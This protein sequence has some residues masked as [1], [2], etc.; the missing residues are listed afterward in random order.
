M[1][2]LQ[3][4]V[5]K[6]S[7]FGETILRRGWTVLMA[8]LEERWAVWLSCVLV[9]QVHEEFWGGDF[10]IAKCGS[11]VENNCENRWQMYTNLVIWEK[12]VQFERCADSPPDARRFLTR[13]HRVLFR[14]F[15]RQLLIPKKIIHSTVKHT[16][17][18]FQLQADKNYPGRC[19]L[20]ASLRHI[21]FSSAI[22]WLRTS[23]ISFSFT[24]NSASFSFFC[25][26]FISESAE[27]GHRISW[28]CR[29]YSKRQ[30]STYIMF[31]LDID[32]VY[33]KIDPWTLITV[34]K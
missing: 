6:C 7:C 1:V 31:Y 5:K 18:T 2:F 26:S 14:Q 8:L 13:T 12:V 16:V 25:S 10:G 15:T 23:W 19:I 17:N 3:K 22:F 30:Y 11:A 33:L 20:T 32:Q 34:W 4:D 9:L 24:L 21:S 28:S 27:P 29:G